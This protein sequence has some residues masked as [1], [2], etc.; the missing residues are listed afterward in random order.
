MIKWMR[1]ISKKLDDFPQIEYLGFW[2]AGRGDGSVYHSYFDDNGDPFAWFDK[3]INS[4]VL[5]RLNPPLPP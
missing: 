5:E 3:I 4:G 1:H 2:F